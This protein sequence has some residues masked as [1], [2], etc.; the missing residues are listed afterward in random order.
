MSSHA[1]AAVVR[2]RATVEQELASIWAEVL[3]VD[4]VGPD[5]DFFALGGHSLLAVRMI[6]R[7]RDVFDIDL[8][9]PLLVFENPTVAS[10]AKVL[11]EAS[12]ADAG[13]QRIEARDP[14]EPAPASFIQEQLWFLDQLAPNNPVYNVVD[15]IPIEG[16][17]DAAAM[18]ET[19]R[20]LVR[21]HGVL[22]T[23]FIDRN[24]RPMQVV[25]PVI[26]VELPEID[27]ASL[28]E[29]ERATEWARV[30]RD[31]GRTPFDLTR[32]P[33]FRATMVH[34]SPREHRL[35]LVIHHII[36][37]EWSM[38]LIHREVTGLYE[39]FSRGWPSPL[40]E[41]SI[42]YTDFAWWQ[43]NG[44]QGDALQ[45]QMSF[46]K[47]EL[48]G[49]PS[50]LELPTDK[51]R[52]ALQ[53]FRGATETF[54]LPKELLDRLNELARAEQ[55]TLFMVLEAAF[56]ALLHRYTGQDDLL[57]GSP[58]SGRAH[59]ETHGLIGCFLN[60]IVLR[61]R[62]TDGMSFRSLLQQTRERAVGA[63]AH[64][65]V[66]FDHL[67]AASAP[68]R[69]SSRT[70]LFQ[71]MFVLHNPEAVPRVSTLAAQHEL[72]TGTSKFDLTLF[73]GESEHGLHGLIEYSTDLYEAESIR[74]FC[75]HYATLLQ[76][77]AAN[78]DERISRLPMVTEA[79]RHQI[80]VEWNETTELPLPPVL[81]EW[82][83]AQVRRTPDD[84]A[85]VFERETLTYGE[86]DRRATRLAHALRRLGVSADVLVGVLVE[87]SLDMVV[88]LVGIMKAGGA[89]LPLDPSFPRER[90]AYMVDDSG[91][92]VLVTHRGLDQAV[93]VRSSSVVYLDGDQQDDG[94]QSFDA[95]SLSP[96]S[97]EQLVHVLYTSGSTGKPK[98]VAIPHSALV[99]LLRVVQRNLEFGPN[100]TLL[101]IS[102]LSF[103]LTGLEVFVPLVSGGRV[104][105]A[106]REDVIDP[107]RLARRI[108]DSGCTVMQAT[109]TT[110]RALVNA[111]W[112]GVPHLQ[113]IT[114][115]EPLPA[116]LA[117]ALLARCGKLWN[118]Y[119]PTE[120]TIYC[121]YLLVTAPPTGITSIGRPMANTQIYPLDAHQNLLPVGVPGELYIGGVCLAREYLHR[122][123]LTRERFVPN[124][125]APGTRLYRSGD[126]GRWLPDGRVEWVAR[127]DFQVKVR[128]FR[129]EPGEIEATIARHPA[130]REAVVIA[131]EDTP[132]AKRL[133]AY[134]VAPEAPADVVDELRTLIRTTLPD[135]MMP[136]R[137][138]S[139]ESLPRTANGK[140]DRKALP[141]P[142]A[143]DGALS[144][145]A[146]PPRTPTEAAV[147]Q[148]FCE[149]MERSDFGVLQSFFDL[150]GHSLM[151]A[152]LMSR[153]RSV[154]RVDL[155]LRML[156]ERPTVAGLAEAIDALTWSERKAPPKPEAGEREE[157][158]L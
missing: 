132:G 7:I 26:E 30:T 38:D 127:A 107:E 118:M 103:D 17:Y 89:Y 3:K 16:A 111:G 57:I 92:R 66:P 88:A 79:E 119:G 9:T 36:A 47:R 5:D 55:A 75:G 157:I 116:D 91:M 32:A 27:L 109:P 68:E 137:F 139:L 59:A 121:T 125:F 122:A 97:P 154:A 78:P 115:G 52:P 151:A 23:A 126:V 113:I 156:F 95:A 1:A 140:V 67:V 25:A 45:R 124:P 63:Y 46:W 158:A 102:T 44:L 73:I 117:H 98:G 143:E 147:M 10:L 6:A 130:I 11:E 93:G 81:P 21:R 19:I 131:R 64:A 72:G 114:G 22:R 148:V 145:T 86:L 56:A 112:Q 76:G 83:E 129:I 4:R 150:G 123:E 60:T 41:L 108:S 105:I 69:D 15:V 133:V 146:V 155:P 18:R 51:P 84:V 70:P 135:Y 37:D 152:R 101:A 128:G 33:L 141:A 49:A 142:T 134:F 90:L 62:F 120:T 24:G 43:R 28:P 104:V 29:D 100:D 20:E 53:S 106:S 14:S 58:I 54:Q 35:L 77:I 96:C 13:A 71:V 34:V 42:Q 2:P 40:P 136:A 12:G 39:A 61:S 149:V 31:H 153:L 8:E 99:N 74:R 110:W 80:V 65:D 48:S 87:R 82:I 50:T 94:E 144:G 138:V 85:V